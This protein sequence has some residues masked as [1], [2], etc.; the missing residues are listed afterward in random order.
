[1]SFNN[2]LFYAQLTISI[3]GL[4]ITSALLFLNRENQNVFLPIFTSIIFAWV[5]SPI[6]NTPSSAIETGTSQQEKS[7]FGLNKIV[8]KKQLTIDDVLPPKKKN[9]TIDDVPKELD[10]V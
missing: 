3:L 4:S 10:I 5:P 7:S 6:S 8:P 2:N 1:M 9:I